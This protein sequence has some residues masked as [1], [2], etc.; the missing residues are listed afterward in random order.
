MGF[1]IGEKEEKMTCLEHYFENLLFYGKDCNGDYNKN[2]LMETERNAVEICSYYVLYSL[3]NG[4]DEFK[5]FVKKELAEI[6]RCKDCKYGEKEDELYFCHYTG[7]TWNDGNF[8][9][10]GGERKE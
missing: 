4:R 6:I 9:C 2:A 1:V 3:F 7:E 10:A 8:Y 5:Q